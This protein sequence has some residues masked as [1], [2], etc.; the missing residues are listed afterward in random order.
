MKTKMLF[1]AVVLM[2]SLSSCKKDLATDWIGTYDG[3]TG[4]GN[5]QRVVVT[6]VNDN[7]IKLELQTQFLTSYATFATMANAKVSSSTLATVDE[8][9][10][11]Y[12]YTGIYRFTGV[13]SRNGSTLTITNAMATQAGATTLY[14]NFSGTR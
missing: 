1:I 10:T 7:T 12:G 11:V 14:Y 3:T 2:A 13:V 9:G 8:D 4:S 6:K 5:V